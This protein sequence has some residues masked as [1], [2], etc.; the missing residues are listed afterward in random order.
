M[1]RGSFHGKMTLQQRAEQSKR[2]HVLQTCRKRT[3]PVVGTAGTKVLKQDQAKDI[4]GREIMLLR[5]KSK[6]S[7]GGG[8]ARTVS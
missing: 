7:K 6:G 4:R 2:E 1:V 5:Q 8:E 3:F